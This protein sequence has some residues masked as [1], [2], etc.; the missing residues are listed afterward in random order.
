[1]VI[2]DGGKGKIETKKGAIPHRIAPFF[3]LFHPQLHSQQSFIVDFTFMRRNI[4]YREK[5]Y[6]SS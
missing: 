3:V 4:F 1:M 2:K 6:L 5:K